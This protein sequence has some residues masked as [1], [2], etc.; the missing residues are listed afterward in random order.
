MSTTPSEKS[1]ETGFPDVPF[2]ALELFPT[3]TTTQPVASTTTVQTN[4]T[5]VPTTKADAVDVTTTTE[6]A[7][8]TTAVPV[9]PAV[10]A[11]VLSEV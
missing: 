9:D 3:T 7:P 6:A 10:E 8:T 2:L 4:L 1:L 5:A 11:L